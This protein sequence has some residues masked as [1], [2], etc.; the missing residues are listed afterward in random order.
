MLLNC[1]Y[2]KGEQNDQQ[3]RLFLLSV[4]STDSKKKT[5]CDLCGPVGPVLPDFLDFQES[6]LVAPDTSATSGISRPVAG[7]SAVDLTFLCG[8]AET[9]QNTP[10]PPR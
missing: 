10:A 6:G 5:L 7:R 9:P 3:D 8:V 1:P 4:L 2:A